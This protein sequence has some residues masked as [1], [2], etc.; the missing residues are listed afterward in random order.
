MLSKL[1]LIGEGKGYNNEADS[2]FETIPFLD[3]IVVS[4]RGLIIILKVL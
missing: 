2:V 4:A 3:F 1:E